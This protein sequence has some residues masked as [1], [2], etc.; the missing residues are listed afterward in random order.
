MSVRVGF[1]ELI[2]FIEGTNDEKTRFL[3]ILFKKTG[4]FD[5]VSPFDINKLTSYMFSQNVIT[6][7]N[8]YMK[9]SIDKDFNENI[10]E[11][12]MSYI[13]IDETPTELN[14]TCIIKKE[15][16]H[17]CESLVKYSRSSKSGMT[18]DRKACEMKDGKWYC[19]YHKRNPIDSV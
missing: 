8:E 4:I 1:C 2:N 19:G 18:C 13:S 5:K 3:Y 7:H 6:K 9:T 17:Y 15:K 16:I 12:I 10:Y 11:N 14:K